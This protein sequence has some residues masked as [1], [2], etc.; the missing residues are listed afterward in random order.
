MPVTVRMP[1][2]VGSPWA[3][4]ASRLTV[5]RGPRAKYQVTL[6]VRPSMWQAAHEPQAAPASDQRPR[7]VVNSRLPTSTFSAVVPAVGSADEASTAP[8]AIACAFSARP[9]TSRVPSFATNAT[10][11][12]ALTARPIGRLNAAG[13]GEVCTLMKLFVAEPPLVIAPAVVLWRPEPSAAAPLSWP[14]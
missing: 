2:W 7:P 14:L 3:N 11:W 13:L 9:A 4:V 6:S 5:W 10:P 1:W 8:V 12:F